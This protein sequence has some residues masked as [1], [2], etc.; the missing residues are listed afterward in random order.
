MTVEKKRRLYQ[1]GVEAIQTLSPDFPPVYICPICRRGFGTD[2]LRDGRLTGEHVPPQ[3]VGG[4]LMCLT[5]KDCNNTAGTAL[6]SHLKAREEV[7]SFARAVAGDGAVESYVAT[8]HIGDDSFQVEVS[9]KPGEAVEIVGSEERNPPGY[10][11]RLQ[12]VLD[13]LGES[14]EWDGQRFSITSRK[15]YHPWRVQVALLKAAFL[16]AFARFGYRYALHPTLNVVREQI[17]NPNSQCLSSFGGR[18]KEER[19]EAEMWH[20]LKPERALLVLFDRDFVFLPDPGASEGYYNRAL[21]LQDGMLEGG[22]ARPIPWPS[23]MQMAL[24]KPLASEP[25]EGTSNE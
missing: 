15:H 9:T 21:E 7:E 11:K 3:S 6:E 1:T 2:D 12:G 4:R 10:S 14:G 20:F 18:F 23:T 16:A 17:R 25:E 19:T 24:D 13:S 5:C 22:K 8:L